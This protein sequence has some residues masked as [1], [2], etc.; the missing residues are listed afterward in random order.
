VITGFIGSWLGTELLGAR[1]PNIGGFHIIPSIIGS[2]L[3]LLIFFLISRP[4]G[5]RNR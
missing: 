2:I 1:G 3:T 5:R 4:G